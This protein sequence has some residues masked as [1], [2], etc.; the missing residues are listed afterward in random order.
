M[1]NLQNKKVLIT[2]ATKG[3]GKAI[4]EEFLSLGAH[5]WI[6]SRTEEDVKN[7]VAEN[8]EKGHVILGSAMDVSNYEQMQELMRDI[9]YHWGALD[10]LVNNAGINIRKPT[11]EYDTE[12]FEQIISVNLKSVWDLSRLC[13]P[14]LKTSKGAVV[15]ISSTASERIVRT[16]TAA[17]AM[18]KAGIDQLTRFLAVE[19]GPHQIRVNAIQPWYIAT[20]LA[21]QVLKDPEKKE[22]ILERTPLLRIGK[23]EEVAKAV[24]FLSMPASSY[25]TGV[26]LPV[27]GGFLALGL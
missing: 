8:Q 19:W 25:I 5:V 12:D 15:N 3:I 13:F 10:V 22:K 1:W 23:P 11:L 27:D 21:E 18:S 2:G 14:Y 4:T 17:Y 26:C 6:V 7:M 16:S 9:E 20:P 24:A